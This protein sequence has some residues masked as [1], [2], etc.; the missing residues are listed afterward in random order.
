MNTEY[1]SMEIP[2]I[3]Y[4]TVTNIVKNFLV[5]KLVKREVEPGKISKYIQKFLNL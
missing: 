3:S 5:K 1:T 4:N 2:T